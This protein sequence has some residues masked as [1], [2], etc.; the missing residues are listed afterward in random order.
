MEEWVTQVLSG[1]TYGG[2]LFILASGFTLGLGIMKI[3]NIAHGALYLLTAYI[4]WT[5]FQSTNSFLL[6]IVVCAAVG[7]L[8]ALALYAGLLQRLH[9]RPLAQILVT[10]G[11]TLIIA[12]LGV[13]WWGGYPR[14]VERP[15]G[16]A[17]TAQLGGVTFPTYRLFM[18]GAA[19]VIGAVLWILLERTRV[20]ALVRASVDDEEM[21]RGMGVNV[22]RL[23]FLV[24]GTTGILAGLAGAI[25]APFLG[26]FQGAQFDVLLLALLVSVIGGLGSIPGAFIAALLIGILDTV[27]KSL[28]PELAHFTLFAPLLIILAVRPTGLFGKA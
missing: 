14:T 23:Y 22:G 17:G 2:L 10:M 18:L 4:A 8:L 12:E 5:V 27:G 1:L 19:I 7:G 6:V 25:G 20:G 3:V 28:F 26:A 16:L 24:F 21:A 13:I 11:V 15:G 9:Q